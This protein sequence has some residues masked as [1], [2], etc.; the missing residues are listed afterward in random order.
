MS[1]SN[2]KEC[3]AMAWQTMCWH[4][5]TGDSTGDTVEQAMQQYNV[6]GRYDGI[7]QGQNTTYYKARHCQVAME[8]KER[9]N[10]MGCHFVPLLHMC[11]R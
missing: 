5:V 8:M 11:K 4:N 9:H 7:T 1:P 6:R 3:Q 2:K 10:G